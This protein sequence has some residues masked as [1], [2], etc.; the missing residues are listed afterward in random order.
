MVTIV[1]VSSSS[2]LSSSPLLSLVAF[3]APAVF[4]E[5]GDRCGVTTSGGFSRSGWKGRSCLG[6]ETQMLNIF[7]N[8]LT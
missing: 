5:D 4:A 7:D 2:Y 8:P 6:L 3:G 1:F